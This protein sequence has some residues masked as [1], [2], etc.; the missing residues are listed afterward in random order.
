MAEFRQSDRQFTPIRERG[1]YSSHVGSA[2]GP[3]LARAHTVACA[4]ATIE[5]RQIVETSR[6]RN[7][8]NRAT[9]KGRRA[10]LSRD[11]FKTPIKQPFARCGSV[12]VEQTLK[13][14]DRMCCCCAKSLARSPDASRAFRGRLSRARKW[15]RLECWSLGPEAAEPSPQVRLQRAQNPPTGPRQVLARAVTAGEQK[16]P[17][18]LRVLS[19]RRTFAQSGCKGRGRG[20]PACSSAAGEPCARKD[21]M[22]GDRVEPCRT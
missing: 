9:G 15:P 6:Q 8:R 18:M 11:L 16:P 7:F 19:S 10:Q 5:M 20:V 4:E 3:P 22:R 12:R 2:G 21:A 17:P 1:A 14:T 13:G